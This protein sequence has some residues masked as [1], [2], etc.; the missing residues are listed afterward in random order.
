[1]PT[2]FSRDEDRLLKAVLNRPKKRVLR[3]YLSMWESVFQNPL[4]PFAYWLNFE[5]QVFLVEVSPPKFLS[6]P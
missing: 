3:G 6:S 2:F 1:M 5:F 4:C